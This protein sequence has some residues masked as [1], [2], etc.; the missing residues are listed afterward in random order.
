M[1]TA[2]SIVEIIVP[3]MRIRSTL[4]PVASAK[5]RLLPTAIIATPV[6]ERMNSHTR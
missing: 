1:P 2:P 6:R 4:T 5:R 3:M